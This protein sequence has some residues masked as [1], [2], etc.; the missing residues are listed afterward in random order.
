[1]AIGKQEVANLNQQN[2]ALQAQ[3]TG[4]DPMSEKYQEILG[5][6]NANKDA[7]GDAMNSQEQWNDAI[8]DLKIG[9]LQK[10]K[11]ELS[12]A[13]DEYQRQL[14]LNKAIEE[15]ERSKSQR[16]TRIL[17]DG[18]FKYV[19]DQKDVADKQRDL[20][21]KLHDE[22]MAKYDK[23]IEALEDNKK[24][25]NVYPTPGVTP[26]PDNNIMGSGMTMTTENRKS[27][28]K[29]KSGDQSYIAMGLTPMSTQEIFPQIKRDDLAKF[30][31]EFNALD[32]KLGDMS[33]IATMSNLA[34][35][36]KGDNL[37]GMSVQIE[38]GAIVINASGA[39]ANEVF[40][41][42]TAKLPNAFEQKFYT[43]NNND[44][45]RVT[46]PL[47]LKVG[48]IDCLLYH[49]ITKKCKI[50]IVCSQIADMG[51]VSLPASVSVDYGS[52]KIL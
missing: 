4:L 14:D 46:P 50:K 3:L 19:A 27:G 29:E 31:S 12:K 41:V 23:M 10:Q 33:S 2:E 8:T 11:E 42:F 45:G 16:K 48:V 21:Q 5:K 6:I 44:L 7:I 15:L 13:N 26:S 1:M 18:Q 35:M 17:Q 36:D 9:E 34:V 24:N 32:K 49:S 43:R 39:D 22:E 25:D 20:D 47:Y 30:T 52:R 37:G 40:S 51:A 38:P 28:N